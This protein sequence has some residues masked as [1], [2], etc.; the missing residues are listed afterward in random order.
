MVE[1]FFLKGREVKK[2]KPFWCVIGKEW[3]VYAIGRV[4]GRGGWGLVLLRL[5]S[6]L[7]TWLC[8]FCTDWGWAKMSPKCPQTQHVP[9]L[10]Q[11]LLLPAPQSFSFPTI[12]P[13]LGFDCRFAEP[14][15]IN[16]SSLTASLAW[17]LAVWLSSDRWDAGS[18]PREVAIHVLLCVPLPSTFFLL[19]LCG[20]DARRSSSIQQL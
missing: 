2:M 17:W 16:K 13:H 5:A 3:T 15:K 6:F 10:W 19:L 9:A 18:I 4:G 12:E 11:I 20:C 7:C 14:L 8:S 1:V